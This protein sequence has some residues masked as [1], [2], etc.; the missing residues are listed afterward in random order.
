MRFV[1]CLF[2]LFLV[3][4][5]CGPSMPF[6]DEWP[7]HDH[8]LMVHEHEYE[9]E[10]NPE[11]TP[12]TPSPFWTIPVPTNDAWIL[13][14]GVQD[15]DNR[16]RRLT[17]RLLV[18]EVG[19]GVS[20]AVSP[21]TSPVAIGTQTT[22]SAAPDLP[23]RPTSNAHFIQVF[24]EDIPPV[25]NGVILS[26]WIETSAGVTHFAASTGSG[27]GSVTDPAIPVVD[28]FE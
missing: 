10:H 19:T 9:H 15:F 11:P 16:A 28:W 1:H 24:Y 4:S 13:G 25:N 14:F 20:V 21:S 17:L 3:L 6:S 26:G 22:A 8:P 18:L 5:A 23:Y 12:A 7:E 27:F 2:I